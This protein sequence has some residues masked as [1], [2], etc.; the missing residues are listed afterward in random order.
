MDN[1]RQPGTLSSEAALFA[2]LV[3]HLPGQVLYNGDQGAATAYLVSRGLSLPNAHWQM[4][5][6]E[7]VSGALE[8][9]LQGFG[10][11]KRGWI[12]DELRPQVSGVITAPPLGPCAVLWDGP[13][14]FGPYRLKSLQRLADLVV[15][16]PFG[17]PHEEYCTSPE[18]Y[19]AFLSAVKVPESLLGTRQ[20]IA[21]TAQLAGALARVRS[22]LPQSR[23]LRQVAGFVFTGGRMAQRGYYDALLDCAH[24]SGAWREA[25]F[26]PAI[27]V[28][29]ADLQAY[30]DPDALVQFVGDRLAALAGRGGEPMLAPILPSTGRI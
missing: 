27:R 16:R 3:R 20:V 15:H 22:R 9:L 10:G 11:T 13:E 8:E 6:P 24:L 17:R 25:G 19:A 1:H 4:E 12:D 23:Y 30:G 18:H 5:L 2:A 21:N 28:A 7:A 26:L 14:H 29:Y